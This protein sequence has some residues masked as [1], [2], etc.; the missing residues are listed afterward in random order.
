MV[1]L[2][3]IL[4]C[5]GF[6]VRLRILG[7]SHLLSLRM[8]YEVKLSTVTNVYCL[9]IILMHVVDESQVVES[10]LVD[11]VYLSAHF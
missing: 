4:P 11:W 3:R 2:R 6:V 10:M 8:F 7:G 9:L 5:R 1:V